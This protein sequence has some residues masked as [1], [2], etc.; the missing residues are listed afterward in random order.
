MT[1]KRMALATGAAFL[2]SQILAI[3]VHGF[4]LASDYEPFYGTLL[5]PMNQATWQVMLLPLSHLVFVSALVWVFS[6]LDLAGS[7]SMRGV[8]IGVLGWL[9]GQVPLWL[10]WYAEQPWPDSLVLKQLGYELASS[11]VIGLTIAFVSGLKAR[12]APAL[13]A[14]T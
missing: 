1:I 3:A 5:R 2:V 8:K 11:I 4:L 7:T 14:A 9:I 10:L 13:Q 12:S 6:R